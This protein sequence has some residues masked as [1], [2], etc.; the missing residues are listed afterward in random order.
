M[1][2]VRKRQKLNEQ[3]E[4]Q[5]LAKDI[6]ADE[7]MSLSHDKAE[8]PAQQKDPRSLF[9]RLLHPDTTTEDLTFH[10]S[11]TYPI[12]HAVAVLDA[13]SKKCKGYGFV[14]FAD[15][16]DATRAMD[17]L[18]GSELNGKKI[19]VE[20][21][22]A[23]HRGDEA[24]YGIVKEK[25][26]DPY[27]QKR[28]S[29]KLIVRNLPWSIDT[30]EKLAQLFLS[31][32]K[33][34]EAILPK[35]D[36]GRLLGFGFVIV[37]G[38]KNS[39]KALEKL[40]GKVVDGRPL[41]VDWA[42]DK[43]TWQKHKAEEEEADKANNPSGKKQTRNKNVKGTSNGDVDLEDA[44]DI[45]DVD[46]ASDDDEVSLPDFEAVIDEDEMDEMD[47]DMSSNEDDDGVQ[48]E[49]IQQDY[50]STTI[51]IRNLPFSCDDETLFEHF[52]DHGPVRYAR[53][54]FDPVTEQS[55]GVGFVCFYNDSDFE[56][57][58]RQAPKSAPATAEHSILQDETADPTGRFT[59]EGRVLNITK[60][61]EK[62]EANKL[63]QI[64][65]DRRTAKSND[66]RRLYLLNEG[67]IGPGSALFGKIPPSEQV[68]RDASYK[69]RKAL[70][71]KTPDLHLSLTRLAI[72]NIPRWVSAK[73]LKL[74]ARQ[75][76]VEFAVELKAG[77]RQPLSKEEIAR[78]G[79]DM[80]EAER[81]RRLG[82]KGVVKQAKIVFET[83][84]GS[85]VVASGKKGKQKQDGEPGR[86][87]GY[88]FIEYH[89]HRTAL[90]G[91]RWLNGH[92]VDP[93]SFPDVKNVSKGEGKRLIVEFSLEN[94]SVIK[95]RS[96]RQ[97]KSRDE[98]TR[99][100]DQLN[101]DEKPGYDT[102][103][104]R[105]A[106]GGGKL[107]NKGGRN[108]R[109]KGRHGAGQNG[110]GQAGKKQ[111]SRLGPAAAG[112]KRRA[113]GGDDDGGD[114]VNGNGGDKDNI[115]QIIQRKRMAKRVKR[116]VGK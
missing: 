19:K 75:A 67:R 68:M 104:G 95:R 39:E 52:S 85:K 48:P 7:N 89:T 10:F 112:T 51:F 109:E 93:A 59:L 38:Q 29:P 56:A 84:Q 106:S 25:K 9:V 42:A 44:E 108:Q 20:Q 32:G 4:S 113:G 16:E 86:S 69:Q 37:R 55:K 74:L 17:E 72:R 92:R 115:N 34:K 18:N 73:H 70:V 63:Q 96:E 81:L 35:N 11:Q 61:V 43:E 111:Q 15:P 45:M 82:G 23:R 1:A 77:K 103:K 91:L 102:A 50:N 46:D 57:C 88:G 3:G 66:K 71:E 78:E 6:T 28:P 99:G 24:K 83:A 49:R 105:Q 5:S 100:K 12:K 90:M 33:I 31:F 36:H 64:G 8:Q 98:Q 58:I 80:R 13:A 76:I 40:N 2:A 101:D 14:T 65:I 116:R 30:T 53:V 60:A 41:A 26:T 21:A 110:V 79:E 54:V 114:G 107:Q 97:K 27:D 22:Q 62:S 47:V 87:R 94:A